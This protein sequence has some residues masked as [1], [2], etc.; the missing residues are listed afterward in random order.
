MLVPVLR[1]A[2]F[3]RQKWYALQVADAAYEMLSMIDTGAAQLNDKINL[4]Q[5][6]AKFPEVFRS[7]TSL[8]CSHLQ[9][10]ALL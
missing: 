10:L 1:C 3:G 7:A 4:F 6:E 8:S 5:N 2:V 9:V